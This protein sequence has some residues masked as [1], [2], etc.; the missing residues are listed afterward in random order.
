MKEWLIEKLDD[1]SW[2]ISSE[3]YNQNLMHAF[4]LGLLAI[5]LV[6]VDKAGDR[7]MLI[8]FEGDMFF[9][10]LLLSLKIFLVVTFIVVL[11]LVL[12]RAKVNQN[13]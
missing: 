12:Y 3:G 7:A 2:A 1:A 11:F 4:F 9:S 6:L 8:G 13:I 10:L 5:S